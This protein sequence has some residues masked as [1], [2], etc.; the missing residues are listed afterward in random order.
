MKNEIILL[1]FALF[2]S[3]IS[4]LNIK[5]NKMSPG[6]LILLLYSFCA[7]GSY[8]Y[9]KTGSALLFNSSIELTI[10]PFVYLIIVLS[11]FFYPVLKFGTY[12]YS[13][14]EIIDRGIFVRFVKVLFIIELLLIVAFLP[15]LIQAMSGNIGDNRNLIYEGENFITI[16]NPLIL[17]AFRLIGGLRQL[18]IV[19]AIYGYLFYRNER[20]MK[21][22]LFLSL[23]YPI[24]VSLIY[25]M[26]SQI[27]LI[28]IFVAYI[29]YIFKPF[30]S[31]IMWKKYMRIG[32]VSSVLGFILIQIIS[33]SRFGDMVWTFFLR[34]WGE[35][36]INFNNLLYGQLHGNTFG[37]AYFPTIFKIL[38]LK[39]IDSNIEKYEM[40]ERVCGIDGGIFYTFVG[41]LCIEYG[42]I[43]TLCISMVLCFINIKLLKSQNST[44]RLSQLL[45]IGFLG[46]QFIGGLFTCVFQGDNGNWELIFVIILGIYFNKQKHSKIKII[47]E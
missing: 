8:L 46:W 34:Y 42:E 13:E 43:I 35:S 14:I 5:K 16:N 3:V 12:N 28:I 23:T 38:G 9:Y 36:F 29:T 44:L 33:I 20:I 45:L 22:F 2:C 4:L 39:A 31:I 11:F 47:K 19:V 26:R 25:V 6:G 10:E 21:W 7:W 18:N 27:L 30:I 41:N 15:S 32:L 37:T 24:F 1:A 40:I 17:Y